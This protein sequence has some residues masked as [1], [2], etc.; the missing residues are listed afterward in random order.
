MTALKAA[1]EQRMGGRAGAGLC[2]FSS[3]GERL[4]PPRSRGRVGKRGGVKGGER[5]AGASRT[6]RPGGRAR[7]TGAPGWGRG[8][9]GAGKFQTI[10]QRGPGARLLGR[11]QAIGGPSLSPFLPLAGESLGYGNP[12]QPT[13]RPA[14]RRETVAPRRPL[15]LCGHSSAES[16]GRPRA[17]PRPTAG[18]RKTNNRNAGKLLPLKPG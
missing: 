12:G 3:C 8:N 17:A 14:G 1:P 11:G 4:G 7:K 5:R 15:I 16:R 2:G 10:E 18:E 9:G 6:P 13:Q